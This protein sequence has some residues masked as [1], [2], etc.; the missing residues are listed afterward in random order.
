MGWFYEYLSKSFLK[1][2]RLGQGEALIGKEA[3]SHMSAGIGC[4]VF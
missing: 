4:L 2:E 3:Q 1:K